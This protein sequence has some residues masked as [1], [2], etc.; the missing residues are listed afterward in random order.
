M[1]PKRGEGG[2]QGKVPRKGERG[3]GIVPLALFLNFVPV[4]P[5]LQRVNALKIKS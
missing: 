2:S 3:V 5:H 1:V 4:P